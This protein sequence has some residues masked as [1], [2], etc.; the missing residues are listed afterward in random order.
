M[1]YINSN[2]KTKIA[3]FDLNPKGKQSI[4]L[5]HGWPL[6]HKMFE[7]QLPTL[8]SANYRIIMLDLCGFGDSQE[9]A[10]GYTYNQFA[11]DLYYVV[12]S[13]VNVSFSTIQKISIAN[14]P[15][16]IQY[17]QKSSD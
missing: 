11:T 1:Y 2:D 9:T 15:T 10:D 6:S 5:I 14:I 13:L 4:V 3:V 7:Y 12:S 16:T 17:H 8:L